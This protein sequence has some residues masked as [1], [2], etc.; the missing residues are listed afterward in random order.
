M[1]SSKLRSRGVHLVCWQLSLAANR[2]RDV[3][4]AGA[5]S[6]VSRRRGLGG[7]TKVRSARKAQG[8]AAICLRLSVGKVPPEDEKAIL[9]GLCE[10]MSAL[11]GVDVTEEPLS[12]RVRVQEPETVAEGFEAERGSPAS[13][14]PSSTVGN[15]VL[16]QRTLHSWFGHKGRR[17]EHKRCHSK[18]SHISV[19]MSSDEKTS[20]Y[21]QSNIIQENQVESVTT[22]SMGNQSEDHNLNSSENDN[23]HN[24]GNDT[25]SVDKERNVET[26]ASPSLPLTSNPT[27]P[28]SDASPNCTIDNV[29]ES[30]LSEQGGGDSSS[31]QDTEPNVS[32]D[33]QSSEGMESEPETSVEGAKKSDHDSKADHY[34][35]P[36]SGDDLEK[37][38]GVLKS[39]SEHAS[40]AR[41]HSEEQ[42]T[43][44]E[45]VTKMPEG[46]TTGGIVSNECKAKN[47][48][49]QRIAKVSAHLFPESN[50]EQ[51]RKN[52]QEPCLNRASSDITWL[53]TPLEEMNRMPVCQTYQPP[54]VP[55]PN[56]TI[57][58][59][60]ERL[61]D[62]ELPIPHPTFFADTWDSTNVKM[63]CSKNNMYPVDDHSGEKTPGSRWKIIE[64]SL[65]SSI[66]NPHDLKG[67]ILAYNLTY[68]KKWDFTAL[69]DFCQ[70]VMEDAERTH[71]FRSI[72]PDMV[73]LALKLP[74]LCTKPIPLLKKKMNHSITMSQE[75][76][77]CLLANAFFC[78]YPRR[79]A[80]MGKSEYSTY[81][82]INF[83]RMFEGK[84]PK[85]AEKLKT[86]FCYFRRVTEKRPTGL[87]TFTRQ[88]LDRFP[89][90]EKSTKQLSR[91]HITCMGTIEGNGHG[92]L[93]VD[94]ANRYVGGGVTGSGLVQEEIRFIINPELIA[95]RLF[96]EVLDDNEC[97]IVT[98]AEQ[99]SEYKGYSE[100]YK[101]DRVH[102]DQAPRDSWQRRTTEIVAIDAFHFRRHLDQFTPDK[103]KRELNKAYCGFFREGIE[104]KNLSA[105]ATGNWG[106][107]AFGGD[108]RLKALIQLLAAAETGRDV[109]YFTFGDKELMHDVYKMYRLLCQKKKTVGEVY[110]FLVNYNYEVCKKTSATRPETKLYTFIHNSLSK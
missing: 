83:S 87:V 19:K 33:I 89:E 25:I 46:G 60:V 1:S 54:L 106:C 105:V 79:N 58:V 82:D 35:V 22:L 56:H 80:K 21:Q 67:A 30:P 29:P 27:S 93:Q 43:C 57:T 34:T 49:S 59:R 74:K 66:R 72:L 63:P 98:G 23:R 12:K 32:E 103:I 42:V 86:L 41:Q 97:L 90:W 16:K 51:T 17:E 31:L 77:S 9:G 108:P 96:T 52:N 88:S 104:P 85:K 53:G 76:I 65:R 70:K 64:S 8:E 95:S 92:M 36:Q 20:V 71:L 91:L 7:V 68:A 39:E 18:S 84:N 73:S 11:F 99:Y 4:R 69:V 28:I 81:P 94:F 37:T 48:A 109:V 44:M 100:S 55:S 102:E 107:G 5:S 24:S 78:T 50:E 110:T 6:V 15:R 26:K 101:W 61:H 38:K 13:R 45:E 75:Q 47:S 2:R 40:S 62:N 3:L 10:A 14:G